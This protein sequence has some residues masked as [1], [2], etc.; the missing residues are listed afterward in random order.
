MN[1]PFHLH[2][3][4]SASQLESADEANGIRLGLSRRSSFKFAHTHTQPSR[5]NSNRL[6]L[7]A[8]SCAQTEPTGPSFLCRPSP[9]VRHCAQLKLR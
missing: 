2:L 1:L 7:A 5:L 3:F 6:T 9:F 8:S 4:Q